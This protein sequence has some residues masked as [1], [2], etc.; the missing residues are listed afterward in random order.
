MRP[1]C[2]SCAAALVIVVA[3]AGCGSTTKPEAGTPQAAALA[4]KGLN[5]PRPSRIKC[6]R[7][8]GITDIHEETIHG[9]QSF[10]VGKKPSGPTVEFEAT[11]GMAQG[12]QISGHHAGAEIL[13]QALVFPNDASAT[14]ADKVE[15]CVEHGVSG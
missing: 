15:S 8:D 14:L 1:R 13:G 10:Q 7:S 4:K 3:I 12:V 6:L 2:I 5:D 9:L 11:A